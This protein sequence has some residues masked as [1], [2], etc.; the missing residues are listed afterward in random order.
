MSIT[1]SY[2]GLEKYKTC[3]RLFKYHY[4]D[5]IRDKRKSS[6]L[7]FGNAID[8]ALNALLET[9]KL[10]V[11]IKR[12]EEVMTNCEDEKNVI[13]Y[14]SDFIE[15]YNWHESLTLKGMNFLRKY[16]E[17]VL[18]QL[19]D[20][21]AVQKKI[22][23]T[24]QFGDKIIGYIDFIGKWK[25]QDGISIIDNKTSSKSYSKKMIETSRQLALY[26]WALNYDKISY[27]VMRK[28]FNSKGECRPIQVL[29]HTIDQEL[30]DE[31]LHEFDV[32]LQSIKEKKFE[33]TDNM[34]TCKFMFGKKCPY[35]DLCH[36]D[37]S[38]EDC[39]HLEKK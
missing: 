36:N 38:V 17:E 31:V 37:M 3:P 22:E 18:P 9:K 34:S 2:S 14:S 26:A 21:I 35:F 25:D 39:T 19:E 13:T 6:A 5:K 12:F 4:I 29:H 20:V 30:I 1:L 8:E 28:D 27:V 15:G 10:P 23:K 11:A 24:N 7:L 33:P 16:H 32:V